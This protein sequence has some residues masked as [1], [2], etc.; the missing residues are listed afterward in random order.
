MYRDTRSLVEGWTKNLALLFSRPG[1]LALARL[2][3]FTAIVAGLFAL[4]WLLADA[5]TIVGVSFA[6]AAFGL[7]GLGLLVWLRVS[8]R[9]SRAHFGL[10][11]QA[12]APLGLPIISYLLWRSRLYYKGRKQLTWKGRTY[13][14]EIPQSLSESSQAATNAR[15]APSCI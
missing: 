1:R 13:C 10:R 12:L 15:G 8:H 7:L 4:A 14:P 5:D 6:R 11:A 2:A 9:V 3:E